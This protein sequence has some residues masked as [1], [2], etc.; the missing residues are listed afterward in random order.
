MP[1]SVLELPFLARPLSQFAHRK[2][3]IPVLEIDTTSY[4]SLATFQQYC[5]LVPM[6]N[7]STGTAL[8][9]FRG[10]ASC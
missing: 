5:A 2:Q 7:E 4:D 9:R 3:F 10:N 8:H 1:E 6:N